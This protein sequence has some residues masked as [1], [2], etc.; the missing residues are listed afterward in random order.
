ML[1][2]RGKGAAGGPLSSMRLPLLRLTYRLPS[3]S[4]TRAPSSCSLNIRSFSASAAMASSASN[5]RSLRAS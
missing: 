4:P 1:A 5:S 2:W 3:S